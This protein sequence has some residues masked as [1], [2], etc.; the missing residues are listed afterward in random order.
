MNR[1]Q[2]LQV[3]IYLEE[4]EPPYLLDLLANLKFLE[5]EQLITRLSNVIKVELESIEME[6]Y[7]AFRPRMMAF[8]FETRSNRE[9]DPNFNNQNSTEFCFVPTDFNSSGASF[10]Y[11]LHHP[12]VLFQNFNTTSQLESIRFKWRYVDNAVLFPVTPPLFPPPPGPG[13]QYRVRCVLKLKVYCAD[14]PFGVYNQIVV[15]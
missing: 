15:K 2:A 7:F 4:K 13:E 3:Q 11:Q 8:K 14:Q 6:S 1:V 5:F 12:F 10:Q 9:M